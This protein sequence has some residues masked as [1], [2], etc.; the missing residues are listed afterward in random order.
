MK[1]HHPD[2]GQQIDVSAGQAAM[3]ESQGWVRTPAKTSPPA[4]AEGVT[5][6]EPGTAKK[7]KANGH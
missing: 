3:Y 1:L 5:P 4:P 6:A 2:S 7:E